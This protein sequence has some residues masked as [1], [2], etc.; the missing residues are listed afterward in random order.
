MMRPLLV[1][2]LLAAVSAA[3]GKAASCTQG[4]AG[5]QAGHRG[6]GH[7]RGWLFAKE[8]R[9]SLGPR[10]GL[11]ATGSEGGPA[12]TPALTMLWLFT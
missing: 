1:L 12:G 2:L 4:Q 11:G 8:A 3:L 7:W 6:P 10:P 9:C 5:F